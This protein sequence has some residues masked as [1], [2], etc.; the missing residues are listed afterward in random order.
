MV[1]YLA[2]TTPNKF[3]KVELYYNKGGET[4]W[5]RRISPR[6]YMLYISAVEKREVSG[7]SLESYC[8]VDSMKLILKDVKRASK[9]AEKEAEEIAKSCYHGYAYQVA[10]KNG[11]T[12]AE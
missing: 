2:T 11:L 6:A 9:K 3:I 10:V 4:E 1:K 12:L 5:A 8:P 7:A